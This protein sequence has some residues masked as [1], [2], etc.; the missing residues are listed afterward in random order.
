MPSMSHY[1]NQSDY[2]NYKKCHSRNS[3][4]FN[5]KFIFHILIIYKLNEE[6]IFLL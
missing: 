6:N 1:D 4:R 3:Q 5:F 2:K